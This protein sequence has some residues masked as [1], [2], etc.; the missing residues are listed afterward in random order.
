MTILLIYLPFTFITDDSQLVYLCGMFLKGEK[1]QSRSVS[2]LLTI[3][4]V[5]YILFRF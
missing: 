4:E 2:A 5:K 1:K 3:I